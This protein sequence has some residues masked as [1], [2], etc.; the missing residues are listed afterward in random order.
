M[1]SIITLICLM[2]STL[3]FAELPP[4]GTARK[5]KIT[6]DPNN[7]GKVSE[8]DLRNQAVVNRSDRRKV[9]AKIDGYRKRIA[10]LEKRLAE[11]ENAP[12]RSARVEPSASQPEPRIAKAHVIRRNIVTVLGGIG[13]SHLSDRRESEGNEVALRTGPVVGVGYQRFLTDSIALGAQVQV[14]TYKDR[15]GGDGFKKDKDRYTGLASIGFAW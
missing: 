2:F 6:V 8:Y 3:A 10:E 12:V 15:S 9:Q 5:G 14:P 1:K 4:P 11:Y 7:S 13:P